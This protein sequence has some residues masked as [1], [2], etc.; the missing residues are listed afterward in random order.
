MCAKAGAKEQI[1]PAFLLVHPAVRPCR[2]PARTPGETMASEN[3]SIFLT[4][5]R[6][7]H[8]LE[9]EATQIIERQLDRLE[10]YPQLESKLRMHLEETRS[11][12]NRL[13][14]VLSSMNES[15]STFKEGVMGF[16]GSMAALAHTPANDEILKNTFANLAFENYEIAAYRSLIAMAEALGANASLSLLRQSLD[17]ERAMA[18]W[19]DDN[20]ASITM[21]F[22]ALREGGGKA[23]R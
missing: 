5:L 16:M 8:A 11:Q 20:V 19:I 9:T 10:N 1:A 23:D 17:E 22:L 21:Q 6:N 12:K 3:T 14:Q 18:Q 7:A 15:P 13:E 4:G 2:R